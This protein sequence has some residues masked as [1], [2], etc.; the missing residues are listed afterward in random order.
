VLSATLPVD[1]SIAPDFSLRDQFG[2]TVTLSGF[3][4]VS[5]VAI[6]FFPLAFTGT[7]T[8]ELCELRDNLAMFRSAGVQLLGI[9]VDSTATLR[10]FA[11]RE[12]YE[13]TLLA[14]FWPHGEVARRYGAFLD[15]K[16]FAMRAT[17]VMDAQGV[18]RASFA[19]AP[20]ESRPLAAYRAAIAEL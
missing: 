1:G 13:F 6:V 19:A 18:V 4:G 10:E 8:D 12:S 3:R 2:Q 17:I 20:G 15:E 9:S 16:G 7:C 11:E 14:D 5:S